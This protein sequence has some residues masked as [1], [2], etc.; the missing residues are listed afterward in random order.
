MTQ[1][2][3]LKQMIDYISIIAA[4]QYKYVPTNHHSRNTTSLA[5]FGTCYRNFM[6]NATKRKK[7]QLRYELIGSTEILNVGRVVIYAL[8]WQKKKRLLSFSSKEPRS[9]E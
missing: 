8:I 5:L 6:I 9:L 1:F 4:Y 2:E 7:D 3:K